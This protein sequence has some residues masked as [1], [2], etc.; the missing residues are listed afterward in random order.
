VD[1]GVLAAPLEV[2]PLLDDT[3]WS[4][5][6]NYKVV[7]GRDLDVYP[8]FTVTKGTYE[9]HWTAFTSKVHPSTRG[10]WLYLP[11]TYLENPRARLPV[12]YMHDGQ[13]LFDVAT[14]FGGNEWRVDETVDAAAEDGSF[15]E[16][17]VV[18]VE[19]TADRMTEYA[20]P[21]D[22][23]CD[24][25]IRM[26]TDELKPLVDAEL[27]TL[28]GRAD[29]AMSGSSLGGLISSWAGVH[30]AEVFGL[31]GSLSPSTS[32]QSYRL[33]D[34]IKLVPTLP[35]RADRVYIDSGDQGPDPVADDLPATK[36]L[37]DAYKAVG[38][39]EGTTLHYV[40]QAGALHNEVYWA[41]RLPGALA[42]LLGPGR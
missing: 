13:N 3:T 40:V 18:G 38:Y 32:F 15:R 4:R 42:F 10:V 6:P 17:I 36:Q 7:P 31:I 23:T 26:I 27:R 39:T 9:V 33:L 20:L 34:E 21:P 35:V 24:S 30:R 22:G 12:V 1:L 19:N 41:Q 5:G 16:A 37:D 28:P 8:H 29:T 2:K 11:P 14:A 25:Y